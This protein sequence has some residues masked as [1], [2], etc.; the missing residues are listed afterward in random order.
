MSNRKAE[1]RV[2]LLET[3]KPVVLLAKVQAPPGH[4]ICLTKRVL[5][6]PRLVIEK[7]FA[8]PVRALGGCT[9]S[10]VRVGERSRPNA[11]KSCSTVV[12]PPTS[13]KRRRRT[14]RA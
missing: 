4:A 7:M 10:S 6:R 12:S 11:S 13:P 8:R 14:N 3:N 2:D 5:L 1:R 9:Q